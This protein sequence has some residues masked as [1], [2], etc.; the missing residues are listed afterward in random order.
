MTVV[1]RT[2]FQI[3][4]VFGL[5]GLLAILA[6]LQYRW[7]GQISDAE[8]IRLNERLEEDTKRFAEDFNREIQSIYFDF[9]IDAENFAGFENSKP[10]EN[11]NSGA[12]LESAG[13]RAL[14]ERFE[15]WKSQTK[16]PELVENIYFFRNAEAASLLVFDKKEKSMKVEVWSEKLKK[17]KAEIDRNKSFVPGSADALILPVFAKDAGVEQIVIRRRDRL[18]KETLTDTKF[19]M[20]EKFGFLI[21][22]LDRNV[23]V[24]EVFPSLVKK[25][26]SSGESAA[27]RIAVTGGKNDLIFSKDGAPLES[28]DATENLFVLKPKDFVFFSRDL[29]EPS[30]EMRR[31]QIKRLVINETFETTVNEANR[32]SEVVSVNISKIG[33]EDERIKVFEG[34]TAPGAETGGAW[35][36]RVQHR[37]GSLE[38][39]VTETRQRNL[40]VSFG[41]LLLLAVSIVLIFV[42]AQRAKI[43][44]RRQIDF[45]S[46]VSHEFR[47]PL[48][49]IRSA[50]EN[51]SDGVVK[52]TE[53]I[54]N[55]GELLERE[56]RKLSE[57]VEQ[58]L[59]FAGANS[60]KR[61]FDFRETEISKIIERALNECEAIIRE[62]NFTV[63][64]DFAGNLPSID[65]DETALTQAV[66]N[67]IN[68]ALK[69][70]NGTKWLRISARNGQGEIKITV[71]DHGIG[72]SETDR[73]HVFEPFYRS[74]AVVD[75]QISGNGLGLSL[76]KKI[77]EAH[78][79]RVSVESRPG[80]GSRFTIHLPVKS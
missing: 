26:F 16:Y 79:G 20:P 43:F 40:A 67:L 1:K 38:R 28:A 55:Y 52:E 17:I 34:K 45:V 15:L 9:Q 57:M 56:G 51:L 71:E 35:T 22:T 41:I 66:Q 11:S 64:K 6:F 73:K 53:K 75:E 39:F 8:K 29:P 12:N 49:V 46:S 42:S 74:N 25:Y 65:A 54:K 33:R 27:Y 18:T 31:E 44:A 13:S 78:R 36:V 50:G 37:S 59:A 60:G 61:K 70:S 30:A 48:A 68:N 7:L 3:S 23:L 2:A 5:L 77:V 69:Y 14:A 10:S 76:V 58:I 24:E 19:E 63:E 4:M 47:T 80:A 72:I 21:V 62:K 32:E